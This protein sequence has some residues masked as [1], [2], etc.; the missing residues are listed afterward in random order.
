MNYEWKV[1][2]IF[3]S[4][5]CRT[6][7][8]Y[9]NNRQHKYIKKQ[10]G[11]FCRQDTKYGR[12]IVMPSYSYTGMESGNSRLFICRKMGQSVLK[13]L[14]WFT[15][16]YKN[17]LSGKSRVIEWYITFPSVLLH[18]LQKDPPRFLAWPC[19]SSRSFKGNVWHTWKCLTKHCAI[20]LSLKKLIHLSRHKT[21]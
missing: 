7:V 2:V 3:V 16:H 20:F 19:T 6:F 14:T 17:G 13:I 9:V 10:K 1:G 21:T 8:H 18:I 4:C 12:C 5:K 11:M 15:K